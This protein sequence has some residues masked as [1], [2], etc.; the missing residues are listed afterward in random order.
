MGDAAILH[1]PLGTVQRPTSPIPLLLRIQQLK[2]AL[3]GDD[4]ALQMGVDRG[5]TLHRR[6]KQTHGDHE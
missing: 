6:Q 5:Q 1:A 2:Q 3:G 4:A